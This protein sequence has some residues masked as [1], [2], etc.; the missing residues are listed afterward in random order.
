MTKTTLTSQE[1][2]RNFAMARQAAEKGPVMI[3]T[4][5]HPSHVLLT[6]ADYDRLVTNT[7]EPSLATL[8]YSPE[9]ADVS[10]YPERLEIKFRSDPFE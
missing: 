4:N 5:G 6:Y 1:V 7:P 3:T 10:F 8:F 2:A 9:A